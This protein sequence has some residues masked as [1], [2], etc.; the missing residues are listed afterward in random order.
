LEEAWVEL[1]RAQLNTMMAQDVAV[2]VATENAVVELASQI[3][4]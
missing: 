4:V 3:A 2:E 1:V